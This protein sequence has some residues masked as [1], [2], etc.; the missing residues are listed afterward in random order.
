MSAG[1][2]GQRRSRSRSTSR[3]RGYASSF[4]S[5]LDP[6]GTFRT[7]T[8]AP[9]RAGL[10]FVSRVGLAAAQLREQPQDLEVEPDQRDQQAERAVPLHVLRR[11]RRGAV[12]DEVEVEHEV[13]SGDDD[14]DDAHADP[15]PAGAEDRLVQEADLNADQAE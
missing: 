7:N 11:A 12:L 1:R 2:C 4:P 8:G 10:L 5:D 3:T 6:S 13:Q 9:P 14:D 15:E